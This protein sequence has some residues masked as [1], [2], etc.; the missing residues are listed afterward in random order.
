[1]LCGIEIC[2]QVLVDV[3][4]N[5]WPHE[6]PRFLHDVLRMAHSTE[7]HVVLS[8]LQLL[9]L[10]GEEFVTSSPSVRA[11]RHDELKAFITAELPQ[12]LGVVKQLLIRETSS[13][14]VGGII[15]PAALENLTAYMMWMPIEQY[16][17]QD[18]LTLLFGVIK[19]HDA[20]GLAALSCVLEL[21]MRKDAPTS[22]GTILAQAFAEV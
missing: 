20:N 18:L 11:A 3:A 19:L 2:M 5:E 12:V 7:P 4:K 10:V 6:Y 22:C 9:R 8:A 16:L 15:L 17:D 13:G 21:L 14:S 1:M